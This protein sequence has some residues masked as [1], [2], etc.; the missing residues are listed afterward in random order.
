M[1]TDTRPTPNA[2]PS[3]R[4]ALSAAR[5]AVPDPTPTKRYVRMR[6]EGE[7]VTDMKK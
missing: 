5:K 6:S 2:F 4:A 1:L 3:R 7:D